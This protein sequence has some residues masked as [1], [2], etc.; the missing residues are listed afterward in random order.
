MS[1]PIKI[2][3]VHKSLSENAKRLKALR[4][5]GRNDSEIMAIMRIGPHTFREL[6]AEIRE[7]DVVPPKTKPVA[8]TV[9]L[10]E[11]R[12]T[13]EETEEL[14]K[15][16]LDGFTP[17]EIASRL[18]RSLQSVN[19]KIWNLRKNGL[20]PPKEPT[21]KGKSE[22]E[23]AAEDIKAKPFAELQVRKEG[24]LDA[25]ES[26]MQ[27]NGTLARDTVKCTPERTHEATESKWFDIIKDVT[28]EPVYKAP[29]RTWLDRVKD[30]VAGIAIKL[31]NEIGSHDISKEQIEMLN[32]VTY[33]AEV[34][35]KAEARDE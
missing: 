20:L 24:P 5:V 13:H 15:M 17:S 29:E 9:R 10:T 18:S 30:S 11:G 32:A 4:K 16:V 2:G 3:E 14:S 33:A 34:L 31:Y 25:P 27:D 19:A 8:E 28:A 7:A 22:L 6:E 21:P 1:D 23:Q 26:T 12:F 35:S